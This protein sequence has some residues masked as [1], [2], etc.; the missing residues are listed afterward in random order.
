MCFSKEVSLFTFISGIIGS[1]L[2]YSTGTPDYKIIGVFFAFVSLMQAIEYLLWSHPV[3]DDYNK[4][5]SYV[6]MLINHLQPIV[7]LLTLYIYSPAK[8]NQYKFILLLLISIYSVI[9]V[10]YSRKFKNECTIKDE[11][12]NLNWKWNHMDNKILVY[13]VFLLCLVSFGFIFPNKNTGMIFSVFSL[14]SYIVSYFIYKDK[15]VVG[16]M[17]CFFSSFAPILFYMLK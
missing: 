15:N 3:C 10:D 6:A 4:K 9:I 13:L 17:W 8:F 11:N 12:N 2:C 7:L 16:S 5:L 1:L 14:V